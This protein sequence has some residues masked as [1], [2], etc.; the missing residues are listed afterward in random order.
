ME[1]LIITL[2]GPA[3]SGKSTVAGR[4][5][6]RLG[7]EFLDTG[8]MYRGLTAF[9]LDHGVSPTGDPARVLELLSH[10]SLSFDWKTNP[11]RL[12][13]IDNESK[14]DGAGEGV[15]RDVT[16]RL[17]DPDVT[18]NVSDIASIGAIRQM[19]VEA[20]RRIGREHA[21]LVTE[22]RDQGSVVFPDAR[23][24]F[25]LDARPE[26]RARRRTEQLRAA[27][28]PAD[29]GQILEQILRRDDR[30]S[31]RADGPLICPPDANRVDTSNM[32]LDEVVDYLER[33]VRRQ[34]SLNIP[35][36]SGFSPSPK[37]EIRNQKLEIPPRGSH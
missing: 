26:V 16:T 37:S 9:C 1:P 34:V 10:V 25:Y 15:R 33:E 11:P 18:L 17:R 13:V 7:L 12:C 5:A 23:V 30:D 35:G 14:T 8:A 29:E 32:T 2:D 36:T 4:L 3:G 19:M 6:Q 22:G 27:G 31:H 21:R 28:K 20:Q 24:K